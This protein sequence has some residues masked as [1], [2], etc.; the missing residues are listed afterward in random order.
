MIVDD[1]VHDLFNLVNLESFLN[2]ILIVQL[3]FQ[4][5]DNK[6]LCDSIV[7]LHLMKVFFNLRLLLL[8]HL[9]QFLTRRGLSLKISLQSSIFLG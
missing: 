9:V 4:S 5:V 6:L 8:K 7:F 2:D 1:G 3:D